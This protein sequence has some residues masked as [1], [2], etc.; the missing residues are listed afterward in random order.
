MKAEVTVDMVV[1]F[2]GVFTALAIGGFY[3][4]KMKLELDH[5]GKDLKEIKELM[6]EFL[7]KK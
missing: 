2:W 5:L 1:P 6:H 4:V 3:M 7:V